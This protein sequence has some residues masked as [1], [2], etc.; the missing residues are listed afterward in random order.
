MYPPFNGE[1]GGHMEWVTFG[2]QL[3]QYGGDGAALLPWPARGVRCGFSKLRQ[4]A[5]GGTIGLYAILPRR[6][7]SRIY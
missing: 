4:R 6:L 2:A 1:H 5:V 7:G 3:E